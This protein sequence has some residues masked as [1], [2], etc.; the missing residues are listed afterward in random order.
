MPRARWRNGFKRARLALNLKTHTAPLP[1]PTAHLEAACFDRPGLIGAKA[2]ILGCPRGELRN[3]MKEAVSAA[4]DLPHTLLGG[5]WALD[6]ESNRGSYLID[7]PGSISETNVDK[8]ITT[9]RALGARQIDFHTGHTLRFG[10]YEPDRAIYPKGLASLKAVIDKLHA[11]G[12]AAGLHTY[13]FFVA[14]D[15][16]WVSPVPDPRL[17][18]DATF[19]LAAA[20]T[21][22]TRPC[23]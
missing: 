13:A 3:V 1:G 5:P 18:K 11:A 19:T 15:S 4:K 10:D 20:L 16:K 12:I 23:P 17:G 6:A 7:Y 14:K 21:R 2:A 9:A 8:W 22:P